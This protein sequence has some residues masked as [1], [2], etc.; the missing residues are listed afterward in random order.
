MTLETFERCLDFLD[1]SAIQQARF[2][3]GEPTL[4][5]LFADFVRRAQERG[6]M[7]V[8][9]TN[10]LMPQ[11]ALEALEAL[12]AGQ[13]SVVMNASAS[14][15]PGTA[16]RFSGPPWEALRRL[17]QKIQPGCNID[18]PD[19]DL[20]WVIDLITETGCKRAVRLGL[21]LPALGG[22]NVSLPVRSYPQAGGRILQF[23]ERAAAAGVRVEFDCGFVRCM[24]SDAA[25]A[26]LEELGADLGWR[27]SP[28]IDIDTDGSAFHCFPLEEKYSAPDGFLLDPRWNAAALRGLFETQTA[29]YRQ[30]GIYKECAV[31]PYKHHQICSGGCLANIIKRFS[32]DPIRLSIQF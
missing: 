3:G 9:F 19:F 30:A 1:R 31:C 6:K 29:P 7:I 16:G 10:G 17:G 23:A 2:L 28:I 26:R 14:G 15:K 11:P 25:A 24:F 13:C 20:D 12:P 32:S 8:V 5:P 4:H 27:C 22:E 18:R 21:A